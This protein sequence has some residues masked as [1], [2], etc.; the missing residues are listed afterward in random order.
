MIIAAI[1]IIMIHD[2]ILSSQLMQNW[3]RNWERAA[4]RLCSTECKWYNIEPCFA[5]SI[6]G[7]LLHYNVTVRWISYS[8]WSSLCNKCKWAVQT[9]REVRHCRWR[10]QRACQSANHGSALVALRPLLTSW[11][12]PWPKCQRSPT[13]VSGDHCR[14]WPGMHHHSNTLLTM[15]G[16]MGCFAFCM[17]TLESG[18]QKHTPGW[19]S[20]LCLRLPPV[21]FQWGSAQLGEIQRR[22]AWTLNKHSGVSHP[23]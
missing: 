22:L 9:G 18:T 8:W 5:V 1:I 21:G 15:D 20:H 10:G 17:P 13:R 16:E 19:A 7:Y 6:A 12:W 4:H 14:P 11:P 2:C 3:G 23:Q